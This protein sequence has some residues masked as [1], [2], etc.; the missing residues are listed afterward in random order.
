MFG[1]HKY[2]LAGC[3]AILLWSTIVGLIRNVTEQLGPIGGAAMIYSVSSVLLV[4]FVGAP[5][6]KS[7]STKYLLLGG[8]LFVSY[9]ICLSL[10]LGMAND[11]VQAVEMGVINYLWPCL[12]VLLAVL[13]SNKPVN[14]LLYPALA[15]SFVGVAWTVSGDQGLS[16]AQLMA[17]VQTNPIS[18]TLAL[19]GAFLWAVYCNITRRLAD[20]KNAITWFFIATALALWVK[21]AFSSEPPMVLNAGV[22]VDLLLVALAMGGGYALWNIGIIGGNMIFLATLSYFTPVFSTFLS[23]MILDIELTTSF[24]QG[25]IMVTVASLLCWWL[26]REKPQQAPE[27]VEESA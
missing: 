24:W 16:A 17:N 8:F 4:L 7:F 18:Y 5:K 9:E 2:T 25:V 22:S 11:R 3:V 23:A 27:W 6:L 1:D 14:K 19:T 15:L 21:Y 13:V 12:T 10:A 26:T 20:G